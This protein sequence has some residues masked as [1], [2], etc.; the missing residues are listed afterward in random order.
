MNRI[1]IPLAA[2]VFAT[3]IGAASAQDS[4]ARHR[5][6]YYP[7]NSAAA[8]QQTL[9]GFD[10]TSANA[11]SAFVREDLGAAPQRPEGPINPHP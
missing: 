2:A 4:Y 9:G 10:Q 5:T 8:A 11:Y 3:L 1:R 7:S 6:N